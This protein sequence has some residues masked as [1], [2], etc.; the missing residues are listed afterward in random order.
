[1]VNQDRVNVLN[2]ATVE[3]SNLVQTGRDR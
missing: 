1:M 2:D 3:E